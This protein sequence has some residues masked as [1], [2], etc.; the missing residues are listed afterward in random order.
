MSQPSP[1]MPEQMSD[2]SVVLP[3]LISSLEESSKNSPPKHSGSSEAQGTPTKYRSNVAWF[4]GN[5]TKSKPPK[6]KS[7]G[8][9]VSFRIAG[10]SKDDTKVKPTKEKRSSKSNF[11][12]QGSKT[13]PDLRSLEDLENDNQAGGITH[14]Q[15]GQT[16]EVQLR[17]A[18]PNSD[19]K[20]FLRN[21]KVNREVRRS[22]SHRQTCIVVSLIVSLF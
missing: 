16:V 21:P 17:T 1:E 9:G 15:Y 10:G 20:V 4:I 3:N 18:A 22:Q 5:E 8:L 12:L 2:F 13:L 7:S 11:P 6:S 14:L 19:S